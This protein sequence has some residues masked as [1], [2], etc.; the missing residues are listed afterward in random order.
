MDSVPARPLKIVVI[1][2]DPTKPNSILPGGFWDED[3]YFAA[4]KAKEALDTLES[5]E[6]QFKWLCNHDTLINDLLALKKEGEV[7][8]ILEL[9]DEGWMNHPRME[10]HVISFYEMLKIPFTGS[11][12][13]CINI[14]YDKQA[15]L[16]IAQSIGIPTPRSVFISSDDDLD[17]HGLEYP[18]ILKPN[19]TDGSFGIT[20]KSVAHNIHELK[21]ALRQVREVFHIDCPVIVQEYLTGRDI[22]VAILGN[23]E[24][25]EPRVLPLTEEDYSAVPEGLPKICGFESK[26]DE[27]SPYYG[28][29]TRMATCTKEVQEKI[30]KWS[31]A[32]FKRIECQDYARFDWR[33]DSNGNPRLLEANPNCGWCWDG[34]LPKTAA[35]SKISYPEFFKIIIENAWKRFE[36]IKKMD[37]V[38]CDKKFVNC[39]KLDI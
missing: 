28:I 29:K 20:A 22:N 23:D 26:W 6:Y 9:C 25:G 8:L 36:T 17:S 2:G 13:K 24:T 39:G 11:G 4:A 10:S 33:L 31:Q 18:V 12:S 16:S 1:H 19:S 30:S 32:M 3:D 5:S 35:I 34:H 27:S 14:T 37:E 7:D 15:V 21:T 38:N